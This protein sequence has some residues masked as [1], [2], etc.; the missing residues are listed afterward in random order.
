MWLEVMPSEV[1]LRK[2]IKKSSSYINNKGQHPE[3]GTCISPKNVIFKNEIL[4]DK[5]WKFIS[6]DEE[7]MTDIS[8]T[9][10]YV[11]NSTIVILE[12]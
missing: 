9:M 8:V 4:E 7:I 1:K 10:G 5:Q 2:E 12:E 3:I 11:F 6:P